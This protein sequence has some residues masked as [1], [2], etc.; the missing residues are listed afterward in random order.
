LTKIVLGAGENSNIDLIF[1]ST[2]FTFRIYNTN[3]GTEVIH[4]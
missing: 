3:F 1:V 2:N 4:K